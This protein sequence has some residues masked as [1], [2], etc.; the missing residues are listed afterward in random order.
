M[1]FLGSLSGEFLGL[2]FG[3]NVSVM[4]YDYVCGCRYIVVNERG[5]E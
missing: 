4:N 5:K 2:E 1:K 3:W